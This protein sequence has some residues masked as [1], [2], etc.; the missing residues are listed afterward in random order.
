[1]LRFVLSAVLFACLSLGA[2]RSILA[3]EKQPARD[4]KLEQ[5]LGRWTTSRERKED[6]KVRRYQ[7]VLEFK[8]GELT[9]FTE[10][11]RKKE[12]QFTLNVIKDV[13]GKDAA[14]LIL[15]HAESRYVVHYDFVGER[16]ILV[17]RLP[18]R[19]FEGFSLSGEYQRAEKPK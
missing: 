9:F 2:A 11:G 17:G 6:E 7:L 10:E 1:M 18:N 19:P 16:L 15:G 14:Y 4:A 8:G 3:D 5:F 12:N 13:R